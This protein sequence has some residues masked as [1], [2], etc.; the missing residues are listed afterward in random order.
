[1]STHLKQWP[2][3]VATMGFT[4][5]LWAQDSTDWI[6]LNE[7]AHSVG[8]YLGVDDDGGF[9]RGVEADLELPAFARLHMDWSQS[10]L[11]EDSD[12]DFDSRSV[13][14]AT[15]PTALWSVELSYDYS[16]NTSTVETDDWEVAVQYYP[17]HWLLK[18]GY[19]SGSITA[20][21]R[22]ELVA[23]RRINTTSADVNRDGVS[24]AVEW[25][26]GDWYFSLAGEHLSYDRDLSDIR[27][28]RR[29][30]DTLGE[31]T[32]SQIF[33]LIDWR[34]G[35]SAQYSWQDTSLYG[36]WLEYQL[37]VEQIQN[38]NLYLGVNHH[39]SDSI[40]INGLVANSV[41]ESL[42]YGEVGAR[43]HW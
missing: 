13:T 37:A 18:L 20:S 8:M 21:V 39:L 41:D 40:S 7:P 12:Y 3:L 35:A 16:G 26:A 43:Y 29:L 28:S 5:C 6:G 34:V 33:S 36:G 38:S 1:M 27:L 25:P 2:L 30:R 31:L 4:T 42:L 17:D 14:L 22:P 23:L 32:L 11:E 10:S 24:W 19:I 15:D 9:L